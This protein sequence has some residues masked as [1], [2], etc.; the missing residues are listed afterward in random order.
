MEALA[1]DFIQDDC[2]PY[3]MFEHYVDQDLEPNIV[4]GID[5]GTAGTAFAIQLRTDYENNKHEMYYDKYF[6]ENGR[7]N[8]TSLLLRKDN[9]LSY[10]GVEAE[11]KYRRLQNRDDWHF[12]R[13]FKMQMY[14]D[15]TQQDIDSKTQLTAEG[16]EKVPVVIV[17]AESLKCIK[18]EVDEVLV[19]AYGSCLKQMKKWVITVPAIWSD[20]AK[21]MMRAAA[22]K[23]TCYVKY[24][25]D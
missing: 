9:S 21:T 2:Y 17:F 18:R 16:G 13:H 11:N 23:V 5:F 12:F 14:R 19:E 15:R 7:K 20:G 6:S 4:V 1:S 10:F 24:N 3:N 22:E 8:S 25:V